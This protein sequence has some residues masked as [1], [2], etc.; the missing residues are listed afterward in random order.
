MGSNDNGSRVELKTPGPKYC[1][2]SVPFSPS[3]QR[4]LYS[5]PGVSK[6]RAGA[7]TREAQ[8]E[9]L[10]VGEGVGVQHRPKLWQM[11]T[12]RLSGCVCKPG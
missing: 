3:L 6:V 7:N 5:I 11:S 1:F 2:G 8:G 10:F 9:E 4:P 12:P